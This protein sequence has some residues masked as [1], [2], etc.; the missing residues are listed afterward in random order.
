M[1]TIDRKKGALK[2]ETQGRDATGVVHSWCV[3]LLSD[4]ASTVVRA[5]VRRGVGTALWLTPRMARLQPSLPVATS[6]QADEPPMPRVGKVTRDQERLLRL[7]PL[8]HALPRLHR[9]DRIHIEGKHPVRLG[10]LC[11]IDRDIP[12]DQ[13]PLAPGHNGQ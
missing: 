11:R 6:L 10:H 9:L 8:N 2:A 3:L 4:N 12:D 7:G 13:G 5:G 1:E